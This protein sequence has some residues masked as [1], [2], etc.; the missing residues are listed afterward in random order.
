MQ[1]KQTPQAVEA[2]HEMIVWMMPKLDHFPRNRRFTLGQHLEQA[3]LAA[4][5]SLVEAAYSKQPQA[6]L[7]Q[8]NRKVSVARHLWRMSMEL[9]L[10]GSRAHQHGARLIVNLGRQTGGWLK[11]NS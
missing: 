1:R 6:A 9:G 7:A 4:L 10:I 3:L 8:A 11:H 5:E 2:C